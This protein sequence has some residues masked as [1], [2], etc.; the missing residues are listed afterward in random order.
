MCS[1][2][3]SLPL[4]HEKSNDNRPF[5]EVILVNS[6]IVVLL[7]SG[8]NVSIVGGSGLKILTEK[9]LKIVPHPREFVITADNQEQEVKGLV[10]LPIIID[11]SCHC[12]EALVVP[13]INH[14]FIFGSDFCRKFNLKIDYKNNSWNIQSKLSRL[15]AITEKPLEPPPFISKIDDLSPEKQKMA[16]KVIQSFKII[17]GND[18]LGLTHKMSL[19]IDTGDAKPFRI[20]Q[21]PF[22]PYMTKILHSELDEMLKL[23]VVEP[24]QSPWSSPVLLIKKKNNEY[25]FCF[26]GRKLNEITKHDAYPLPRIDCI[27]RNLAGAKFISSI[28]LRKSFW[29]IP[30]DPASR[31]KTAFCV[32]GR[33]LF[34]FKVTPFGLRNSA[35]AQQRLV[36]KLFGPELDPYI[37]TYLDDF[38]VISPSFEHHVEILKTVLE[39]LTEANLTV[40]LE[41]C[42]FFRTSIKY[43]GY[44]VDGDG[45]RTDP[46][47]VSAMVNFPRPTTSTEVK[48]FVGM[49][50]WYRSFIPHF[51]SLLSPINDLLKGKKKG[52]SVS[53]T[54]AAE[55]SFTKIK[56]ALVSDPILTSPDFGLPFT[57]Q[58]DASATGV[59]GVLTQ[60]QNG[61]ERVIAYA[62]RSLSRAER[63]YSVTERELLGLIFCLEKF[64]PYVEGTK[65]TVITDH[66]SLLWLNRISNPTG[67]LARWSVRLAQFNF[68]LKHRKG[69]LNVVPDFLSRIEHPVEV[70]AFDIDKRNIDSWY[71]NLMQ[72]VLLNP[73]LFPQWKVEND[74]LFKLIP[75]SLPMTTNSTEW[76]CVIP[77]PQRKDVI[78]SCH[79]LPTAGHFGFYKTLAKVSELYYW[80]KMR[81]DILKFVKCCEIC[82][83]QKI[84]NRPGLG[85]MG[86]EKNVQFPWQ[87]IAL[88][89]IGP[90]PRS[91]KGNT[92]LLV[93][94]DWFTKYTILKPLR[95]A[96]AQNVVK[97]LES[98]VFLKFGVPQ[99]IIA[100]NG[101]QF[102]GRAMKELANSYKV[103]KIW[104]TAVYSPQCDFV[105]RT[106]RT[107]GTAIRSFIKDNDHTDWDKELDKIS[108]ALNTARHEV[109]GYTPAFLNFGRHLPLSG[110]YYGQVESTSGI[111][112]LPDKRD[113]YVENLKPLSEIFTKVREKLHAAYIRNSKAYN[114]RRKDF[115][116]KNGDK[117]WR[118]NK[119]LSDASKKFSAKLAPKY[120]LRKVRRKVSRVCY[121]LQ[122]MSNSS[123]GI[124]HIKDLKPYFG[125]N[126]D[127]S[128]S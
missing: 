85:L 60:E 28:D 128:V 22:S 39:R 110:D 115:V 47:K 75:A 33:G 25:R 71:Q 44:I 109:T 55:E 124:W 59:G 89:L 18:R 29:Q 91:K 37:F 70:N 54:I 111:Q 94:G 24:S 87:I 26:D 11:N 56:D 63:N 98:E 83:A 21:Y 73:E 102:A 32:A 14:S 114:L 19:T 72:K 69:K 122:D 76:K 12:L 38:I 10:Y 88:D 68:E 17:D 61:Q 64:R 4:F 112:L 49:C 79:E 48:K 15:N 90:L 31:E 46:E 119:V 126:S 51:S 97:F 117:V 127:V 9:H 58:C 36:D 82:G 42:Q 65:F 8:S 116:F 118:K 30:L 74:I 100:D 50:S 41:K 78:R 103:Q 93:I 108:H 3:E 34:Q 106:N 35:Q 123:D 84:F 95:V 80:P 1:G 81:T 104:F 96:T 66:Y 16:E 45:L 101:T 62:S 105:E 5:V 121:E 86:K 67:R 6:P 13:A 107:V 99:F 52:Q 53:W 77:K 92:F 2:K 120:V 125:S 27:L 20:K 40:N 23:G 57:I 7:D 43:L 113:N